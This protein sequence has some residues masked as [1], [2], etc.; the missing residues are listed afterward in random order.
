M[1]DPS[2][3]TVRLIVRRERTTF[4]KVV[5]TGGLQKLQHPQW[6]SCVRLIVM[7]SGYII[8]LRKHTL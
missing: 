7:S 3:V 8:E 2:G 5:E 6:T 1:V 4:V